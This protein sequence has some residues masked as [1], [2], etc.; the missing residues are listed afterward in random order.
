M[1]VNSEE[2]KDKSED[3]E[4]GSVDSREKSTNPFDDSDDDAAKAVET[5]K[6]DASGASDIKSRKVMS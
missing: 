4:S 6:I 1:K 5:I 3:F 2:H